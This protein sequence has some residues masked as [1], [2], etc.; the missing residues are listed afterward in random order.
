MDKDRLL[1]ATSLLAIVLLSLHFTDDVVRGIEPGNMESMGGVAIL[2]FWTWTTLVP[3]RRRWAYAVL[4]IGAL[5]AALM[6]VLHLRG[7]GVGGAF[8]AS[9]GAFFSIWLL[10]ALGTLGTVALALSARGFLA[11]RVTQ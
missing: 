7:K 8:A 6:P 2:A 1:T 5:F 10:F 4:C 3:A 9:D 11:R